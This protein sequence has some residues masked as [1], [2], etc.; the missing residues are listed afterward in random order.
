TLLIALGGCAGNNASE[1]STGQMG[2]AKQDTNL[3]I[4]GTVSTLVSTAALFNRPEGI[5]TD[6]TNI[7]V[8]DTYNHTIR[9]VVI[10]TGE[11]TTLAGMAGIS[12][13]DDGA[14]SSARFKYPGGITTDG[15][16]LY[17][18]DSEN[19]TVRKLEIATGMVTTLAGNSQVIG[20]VDGAG[21]E[22]SFNYPVGITTDG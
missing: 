13:S 10:T 15:T 4:T 5:T 9:K 14:G 12:G 22:A 17:V 1:N 2:G 3:L 11:V 19:H 7:Y 21:T 6:G 8:A 18:A 16:N 20:S